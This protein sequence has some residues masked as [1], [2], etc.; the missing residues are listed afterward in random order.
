MLLAQCQHTRVMQQMCVMSSAQLRPR[1]VHDNVV[2]SGSTLKLDRVIALVS[3][4]EGALLSYR[5][6]ECR[7][8]NKS[9]RSG[10][11]TEMRHRWPPHRFLLKKNLK[12]K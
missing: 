3:I 6:V 1:E 5:P 7:G 8:M 2:R 11:K 9:G 12:N 10:F 4:E